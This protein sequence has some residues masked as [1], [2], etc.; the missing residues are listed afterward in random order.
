MIETEFFDDVE[1]STNPN[2]DYD[3]LGEY[4]AS[5]QEEASGFFLHPFEHFED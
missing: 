5:L 2:D 1:D 3:V 4:E